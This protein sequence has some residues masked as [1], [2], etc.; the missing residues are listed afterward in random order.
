[1][2]ISPATDYSAI[3]MDEI[4][5]FINTR[6]SGIN[7]YIMTHA[8][9]VPRQIVAFEVDKSVNSKSLQKMADSFPSATRYY[10]DGCPVY[11][12]VDYLG[13]LKQNFEDKSDTYIIEGTNADLRHHIAGLRRRSR[14]FFRSHKTLKAVL[15]VFINA[16]NKFG[17]WKH[18]YFEKNPNASHDLNFNHTRFI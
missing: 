8:S 2:W 15:W 7:T 5:H 10:V 12:D 13:L 6:K 11:K 1:M 17:E 16:Y 9:R 3:E 14:C 18:N 4:Y